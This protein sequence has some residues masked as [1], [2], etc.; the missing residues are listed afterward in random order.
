MKKSGFLYSVVFLAF[1]L[2]GCS[3][4]QKVSEY[5]YHIRAD[6]FE[7]SDIDTNGTMKLTLKGIKDGKSINAFPTIGHKGGAQLVSLEELGQA[8]NSLPKNKDG[9]ISEKT[10][11]FLSFVNKKGEDAI[12][13]ISIKEVG[14]V[15]SDSITFVAT[16]LADDNALI[17]GNRVSLQDFAKQKCRDRVVF[18]VDGLKSHLKSG[19]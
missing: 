5:D 8:L 13:L 3:E 1:G 7:I 12:L 16:L 10:H 2:V 6:N 14:D 18:L 4:E 9:Y 15:N 19:K 11:N 17:E